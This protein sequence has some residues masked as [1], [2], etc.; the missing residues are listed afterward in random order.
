[1]FTNKLSNRSKTVNVYFHEFSVLCTNTT[2]LD[3][4][5]LSLAFKS[6]IWIINVTLFSVL[7]Y[8]INGEVSSDMVKSNRRSEEEWETVG[9][10]RALHWHHSSFSSSV[11]PRAYSQLRGLLWFRWIFVITDIII[12]IIGQNYR[13]WWVQM[14]HVMNKKL[15]QRKN[16]L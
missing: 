2:W 10:E 7:L 12:I 13:Y 9:A 5:P 14:R 3:D 15:L 4:R 6:T 16:Q 1:M 8:C 11:T